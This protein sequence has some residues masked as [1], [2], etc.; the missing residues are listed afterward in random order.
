MKHNVKITMGKD[1]Y[2]KTVENG[3]NLFDF[4]RKNSFMVDSLCGG[5]G[6]CGKCRVKIKGNIAPPSGKEAELLGEDAIKNS[7]RRYR[8]CLC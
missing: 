1:K 4:L 2:E 7:Y 5:K 3:T 8:S 6:L